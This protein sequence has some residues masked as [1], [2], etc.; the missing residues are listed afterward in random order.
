MKDL[1]LESLKELKGKKIKASYDGGINGVQEITFVVG[2]VIS[3][4]KLAERTYI[5]GF[6]NQARMWDKQMSINRLNDVKET[7]EILKIDGKPTHIR[8]HKIFGK[9]SQFTCSDVDRY[10]SFKIL[11]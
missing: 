11:N 10:V 9:Q 5:N 3:S 1:T 4:Y 8:S 6:E 7:L 2:E